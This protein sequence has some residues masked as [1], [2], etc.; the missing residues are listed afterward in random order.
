[1]EALNE[2]YRVKSRMFVVFISSEQRRA[3]RP[4]ASRHVP[5]AQ[6]GTLALEP[7]PAVELICHDPSQPCP[8]LQDMARPNQK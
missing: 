6:L 3:G 1:V 7:M 5:S 4:L 8:P 2:D